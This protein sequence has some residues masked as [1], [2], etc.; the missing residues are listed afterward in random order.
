MNKLISKE[1]LNLSLMIL[2]SIQC[3]GIS[4]RFSDDFFFSACSP[5]LSICQ[6]VLAGPWQDLFRK[7]RG[8]FTR[9]PAASARQA[10]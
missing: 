3:T 9:Q 10:N 6:P 5:S 7:L 1:H 2:Y 4:S 8:L